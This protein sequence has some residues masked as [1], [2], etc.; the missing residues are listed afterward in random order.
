M[1]SINSGINCIFANE[2]TEEHSV[3]MCSGFGSTSRTGNNESRTLVTSKNI[4]GELFNF[5]GVKYD[6]P[7]TFDIILVNVDYNYNG[8]YIDAYKERELKKWLLKD[9]RYW[10]SVEQD[11]LA[12]IEYYCTCSK[13]EI[14]DCGSYSGALLCTFECDTYHAWSNLI[15][16]TYTTSNNTYNT[17]LNMDIDFDKYCVY[18][19]LQIKSLGSGD[20]SIANSTTS[21]IIS[22]TGCVTNEQIVLECVNDV[23]SSTSSNII[24][25]WNKNTISLVEGL[26]NLVLTGNFSLTISYRLP[27]RVGA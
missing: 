5:H 24:G 1:S 22:I 11:D 21:E 25:R 8:I 14:L 17:K 27:I 23:V 7:L 12:N 6:S 13:C 19:S 15:S 9:D 26:N 10:F 18:P 16:K 4:Q 2:S 3:I 20:I